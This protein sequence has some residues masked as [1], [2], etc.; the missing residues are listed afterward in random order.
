MKKF[1]TLFLILSYVGFSFGQTLLNSRN[2]RIQKSNQ[3]AAK[4]ILD[5]E[6]TV[7]SNNYYIPGT[8]MDLI[9][10]IDYNT[11][12]NNEFMDKLSI[13]FPE[14][15]TPITGTNPFPGGFPQAPA[16]ALN[17]I[18]GQTISWGDNDN[19]WGGV[20]PGTYTFVVNAMISADLTGEQTFSYIISGD[21][22]K[23]TNPKDATGEGTISKIP[24]TAE[25]IAMPTGIVSEYYGLPFEQG[26]FS[27]ISGA[28]LNVGSELTTDANITLSSTGGYLSTNMLPNPMATGQFEEFEFEEFAPTDEGVYTF[29]YSTD[30]VD[31]ANPDNSI[32]SKDITLGNTLRRDNGEVSDYVGI[33]VPGGELGNIYSIFKQDTVTSVSF[34]INNENNQGTTIFVRIREFNGNEP[35]RLLGSSLPITIGDNSNIE[36][37]I[38]PPLVLEE[39]T[40]YI[41]LEEGAENVQLAWTTTPYTNNTAWAYFNNSWNNLG[42]L[43]FT[44]TYKLRVHFDD[45]VLVEN[46]ITLESINILPTYKVGDIDINCTLRNLSNLNALTEFDITY[47]VDGGDDVTDHVSGINVAPGTTYDFTHSTPYSATAGEHTINVSVA[48]PNG[49]EDQNLEDNS[50]STKTI[51]V[52]EIF[53]KVVVGEE[54]TGTWCGWCVRGHVGLKDMEHLYDD[55]QWIGIAVHN[56]DPMAN[57]EYDSQISAM[58]GGYPSGIINRSAEVDPGEFQDV[59]YEARKSEIPTGKIVINNAK[60][61]ASRNLT[62]DAASIFALDLDN[63]DYNLSMIIVEDSVTGTAS[64]YAQVNYYS[65]QGIKIKDWEGIDWSTLGNPI[66]ASDMIY[67]HVGRI[68]IG[69]WDGVNGSVPSK[70]TYNESNA[71]TFNTELPEDYNENHIKV[72]VL[73]LNNRTGIIENAAQAHIE[74]QSVGTQTIGDSNS[75]DIFPNPTTGLVTINGIAGSDI[76]VYDM[77]GQTVIKANMTTANSKLDLGRLDNGTYSIEIINNNTIYSKK[78]IL[79]K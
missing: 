39:G 61:D 11:P 17:P 53:N 79:V 21:Q 59:G 41:G 37:A 58:V 10:T 48:T 55:T 29:T 68:I 40:Y 2:I 56:S 31:D 19:D 49:N 72:V 52:D 46:D 1:F 36:A 8:T 18:D 15:I 22:W 38:F 45:V 33:S 27:S 26:P 42:D 75:I 16:E 23:Q 34:E 69:G 76:V 35:G 25:L 13:T 63:A 65:Q 43:G 28:V 64:D 7:A 20:A 51:V 3:I 73:L 60:M 67:N 54:A 6:G 24:A 77:L 47:S 66:P 4:G 44:H 5:I 9:F 62:V 12:D 70:V 78:I 50:K 32:F 14:G 57:P 71:Y 74:V 30:F